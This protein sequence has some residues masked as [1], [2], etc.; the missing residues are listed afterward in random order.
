MWKHK[1]TFYMY[2]GWNLHKVIPMPFFGRNTDGTDIHYIVGFHK[3]D[4]DNTWIVPYWP[5][6]K[7]KFQ[8]ASLKYLC[9][10]VNKGSNMVVLE[11]TSGENYLLEIHQ[12]QI[13]KCIHSNEAGWRILDF[14]IHKKHSTVIHL[15][16]HPENCQSVYFTTENA[17]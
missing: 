11:L 14:P 17:A 4:V 1:S 16:V 13:W 5:L 8:C 3:M 7:K 6:L 15:S 9:K 10:Y 2:E 12:Y